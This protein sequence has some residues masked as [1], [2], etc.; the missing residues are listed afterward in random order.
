MTITLPLESMSVEE[1]IHAMESLWDSL[2]SQAE[3]VVSPPWHSEVLAQ[4]EQSIRDGTDQ[5]ETWEQAKKDILK[6]IP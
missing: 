2:C 4:R 3:G 1:K 6:Q 5:F